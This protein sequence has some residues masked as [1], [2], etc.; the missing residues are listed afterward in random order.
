MPIRSR[1]RGNRNRL[2]SPMKPALRPDSKKLKIPGEQVSDLSK[3]DSAI[4]QTAYGARDEGNCSSITD[5][6]VNPQP[7]PQGR[8]SKSP[9]RKCRDS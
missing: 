1:S 7:V 2:F 4:G 3:L 6:A 5:S 9:A 8:H